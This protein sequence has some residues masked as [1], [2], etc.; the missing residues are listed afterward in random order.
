[1]FLTVDRTGGLPADTPFRDRLRNF[2]EQF[3]LAGYDVEI[4]P[5][6][7]VPLD[8]AVTVC[9]APRYFPST[10]KAALLDVF[11]NRILPDG[12]LGFFHPDNYTFGQPVYLSKVVAAAMNVPGV[13]WVDTDDV[14]PSLNHFKRWGQDSRGE[15]RAG[16]IAMSRLEIARL[17][18]NSSQPENGKLDFFMEGGI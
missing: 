7:F 11:S 18:N 4:E 16:Q 5:P 12:G 10:V 2:L 14:P 6:Q 15:T 1:M 17:D 8:I 13:R 3:R 9:V